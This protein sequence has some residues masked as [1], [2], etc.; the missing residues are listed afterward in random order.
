MIPKIKICGMKH[1]TLEV[2]KLLPDY[3][4]FIFYSKPPRFYSEA[5]PEIPV[6]ILKVGV[7][8][9][10]TMETI[11]NH[12]DEFKLDIVQLHGSENPNFCSELK[13]QTRRQ[14]T[15]LWK[16]FSV[17]ELFDFNELTSFEPIVDKFLFDTKGKNKGGNGYTF[18]WE[19]LKNYPSQKPF[20]LS[21]GIGNG[22]IADIKN[23]LA[24]GLPI[25][26]IDINSKFEKEPGLKN[27]TAIKK[28]QH[29]LSR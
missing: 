6:A 28:F 3:L 4:G 7:F 2:S 25:H 18:N 16:A 17:G 12:I 9:D 13:N 19:L 14:N 10:A 29:E 24:S 20:I 27:I 26:A 21:G 5:V 11:L 23:I 8:V 1:N 22:H 15:E